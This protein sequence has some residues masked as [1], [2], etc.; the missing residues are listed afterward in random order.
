VLQSTGGYITGVPPFALSTIRTT[1]TATGPAIE[2]FA[3]FAFEYLTAFFEDEVS[4]LS[5]LAV[6][7]LIEFRCHYFFPAS[8][9]KLAQPTS[10]GDNPAGF[11]NGK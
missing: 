9:D 11:S 10:S 8:E 5:P 2:S 6:G 7:A 3:A 1:L 4:Y